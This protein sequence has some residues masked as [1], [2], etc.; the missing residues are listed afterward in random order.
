[1]RREEIEHIELIKTAAITFKLQD[2][3]TWITIEDTRHSKIRK[4]IYDLHIPIDK[5]TATE[6]FMTDRNRFVDRQTAYLIALENNQ[7]IHKPEFPGTL[8]SEDVWD[9]E[10][11]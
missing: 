8:Y 1:M 5:G 2:N 11:I 4:T 6:G 9:D 10:E 7:F 3:N